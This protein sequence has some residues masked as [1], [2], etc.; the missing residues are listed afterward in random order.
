MYMIIDNMAW[1]E[2]GF[3]DSEVMRKRFLLNL[4]FKS[5]K[6]MANVVYAYILLL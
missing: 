1:T 5:G 2:I 4:R 6:K 3:R